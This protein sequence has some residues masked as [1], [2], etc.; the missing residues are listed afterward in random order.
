MSRYITK[1]SITIVWLMA[2]A[3]VLWAAS[4]TSSAVAL[5]AIAVIGLA[6]LLVLGILARRPGQTTAESIR[7]V[8]AGR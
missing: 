1:S 3:V 7:N 5:L 4:G 8:T 2:L 6:P